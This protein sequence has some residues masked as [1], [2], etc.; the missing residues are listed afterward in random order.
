[1]KKYMIILFV[2]MFAGVAL[3]LAQDAKMPIST[4]SEKALE[5][6]TQAM[7][8]LGNA[9]IDTA[10]QLLNDAL[11]ED[12]DFF[13]A[14]LTLA[15]VSLNPDNQAE[16]KKY[17]EK[18]I[19]TKSDLSDGEM[20]IKKAVSRLY[21]N[22]QADVT[23]VGKEVIELYPKDEAA[24]N[25]QAMFQNLIKD[26]KG[27]EKTYSDLLKITD[28]P[29]PVYNQLGYAYMNMGDFEAS[30]KAFDKYIELV[31][32]HPNP[33]DSKGDYFMAVKDYKNAYES[34]IK[35]HEINQA[36]SYDK[37]LKAKELMDNSA[38]SETQEKQ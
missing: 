17:A 29:G 31:P 7:D 1:M 10:K 6:Y 26:Y 34:Y 21:E 23:D 19:N 9:E 35:A 8:A 36:W 32:N 30:K 5:L 3:S 13:R 25:L 33:Y 15:F 20:L 38:I 2:F 28:E 22:P 16:F 4:S 14:N 18:T 27:S 37:A 11:K 24:Y 12:P